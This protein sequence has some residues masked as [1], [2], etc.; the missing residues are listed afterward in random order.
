MAERQVRLITKRTSVP[1]KIPTGT[2]G[3]ESSFIRA[4]ELASNLADKKLWGYDGVNVFEYGSESFLSLTG[5]TINGD[6]IVSGSGLF[7]ALSAVT[8]FGDGSNLT[9]I[10]GS[11]D[12]FVTGFTYT[13]NSFIISQSDGSSY[14]AII[15]ELTGLT[16]SGNL[17][18]LDQIQSGGTDLYSIFVTENTDDITRVQPG[19]NIITGGTENEPIVSVVE[20]PSFNNIFF[21][22]TAEGGDLFAENLSATNLVVNGGS[23]LPQGPNNAIQY[24]IGDEFEGTSRFR[25]VPQAANEGAD[26]LLGGPTTVGL[27]RHSR[28]GLAPN[29]R[30]DFRPRQDLGNAFIVQSEGLISSS[31]FVFQI[32][33]NADS[34]WGMI[35]SWRAGGLSLGAAATGGLANSQSIR[36]D[37]NRQNRLQLFNDVFDVKV[38]LNIDDN[39][40]INLDDGTDPNDAVNFSQLEQKQ[41]LLNT[42][43]NSISGSVSTTST[44][45]VLISGMEE[46]SLEEGDY[47]FSFGGWLEQ[48]VSQGEIFTQ[49]VING[50]PVA[51]SEM[52]FRIGRVGGGNQAPINTTHN[53]AN[54]PL[55]LPNNATV[56]VE[57]RVNAGTGTIN[58]RYLTLFKV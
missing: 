39:K 36:F 31:D 38:N 11:T 26:I 17:N 37:I 47:L 25:F 9:G 41:D 33:T 5:G 7:D 44:S 6:L 18:V 20:S 8:F 22:G 35:E 40:I 54:F 1:G 46:E 10:S 14:S 48:S 53:Y 42:I 15:N 28:P 50:T 2:T 4:G 23:N 43:S 52:K 19:T 34:Q 29:G 3:S 55:S 32:Q 13:P 16:I 21:S 24:R 30:F 49:I 45:Y 58:N 27:I 51:G 12:T 56:G 57:W